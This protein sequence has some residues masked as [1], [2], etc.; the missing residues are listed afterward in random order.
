LFRVALHT[1]IFIYAVVVGAFLAVVVIREPRLY[2]ELRDLGRD[3][4]QRM[5]PRPYDPDTPVAIVDIDEA[6]LAAFGQWPWPRTIMAQMTDR[7]FA[8]G[9]AAVGYDIVFPEPD[10]TSPEAIAQTWARFGGADAPR[11]PVGSFPAHDTLFAQAIARAP[12]VLAVAGAVAGAPPVLPAGVAVTG[13]WPDTIPRFGG[14]LSNLDGL[15]QAALGIGAISLN[16]SPDGVVRNVPM[17]VA[18]G[19]ALVP[20]LTMELLRVVQG[21]RGHI[22]RTSDGSGE[23]GGATS[24]VLAMRTGALDIPLAADAGFLV[25]F[26]GFRPERVTSVTDV[27]TPQAFDPALAD[28]VANKIVLVGASAQGLF[29]IRAT[30]IEPAVPGVTVHAEVLEQIISGHF[31]QRPDWMPMVEALLVMTGALGA[32]LILASNRALAALIAVL[33]F[34][35]SAAAAGPYLFTTRLL[36][37]DP[38]AII[39]APILVFLPGAAAGLWAKERARRSIR[40]RFS[41]FVPADLL[42]L[43]EADPETALTPQGA[44]RELTILFIDMRGFSTTTEGM[45][46][47]NVVTLVNTFLSEIS[48]AL[49]A[50][51]ATIDKYIGDAV[52]AFWNAPVQQPDHA[53]LA[54]RALP[55]I[56]DA[57]ARASA[58]IK[59][60]GLND[61]SVGV[62]INTG[63]AAIGFIG[64]RA[65]LSYSCLGDSV[66]LA[67]RLE[68]LTTLYGMWNC[69]GPDTAAACPQGMTALP[70]DLI[71]VK[72]FSRAVEV[73]TVLADDTAG[74][75]VVAQ[76]LATARDAYRARDW[77][78]AAAQFTQ[79]AQM[80][81]PDCNPAKIA[82]LYLDRIAAWRMTPP[83]ADWDASHIA[84][85]K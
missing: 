61:I 1:W 25:H 41:H 82:Q 33:V 19:D 35:A 78:K 79:L 53:S 36:I 76:T 56:R 20:A 57:A 46:P 44:E 37:F 38:L 47:E 39:A 80:P 75:A 55:A 72:G 62:G 29:D 85:S 34:A 15:D 49:I 73:Y 70:L 60:M 48:D 43:I 28:R 31:L 17:V 40:D 9:A 83:P 24:V 42:P 30:P 11:L 64:S 13:R 21:A 12:V 71:S 23:L 58:Q 16:S 66:N 77:D 6:S 3:A 68:G 2:V 52:M 69:V 27:M 63:R 7:L 54:L 8:H 14:A 22:L 67:S 4:V 81:L 50:N 26:A 32:A 74:L 5:Y 84:T 59:G 65:R 18:M 45:S 51:R 10:R